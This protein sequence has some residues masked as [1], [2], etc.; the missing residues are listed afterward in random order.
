MHFRLPRLALRSQL[1]IQQLNMIL[2]LIET[3]TVRGAA[4]ELA[5]SQSAVT[6]SL[7]ELESLLGVPLFD[8]DARGLKPTIYCAPLEQFARDTLLGLDAAVGSI[9]N[10][11]RGHEGRVCIGAN[12]GYAENTLVDTLPAIR[13]AFP[14]LVVY[15]H[16]GSN[17]ELVRQL[18]SGEL[19]FALLSPPLH[20]DRSH[21]TFLPLTNEPLVSVVRPS[22]P[23]ANSDLLVTSDLLDAAWVLPPHQDPLRELIGFSLMASGSDEPSELI[24]AN[25]ISMALDLAARLDLVTVAP[26]SLARPMLAQ[27]RLVVVK[28]SYALTPMRVGVLRY[29]RR[30]LRAGAHGVLATLLRTL[31][32]ARRGNR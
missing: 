28:T 10:L 6:K 27:G 29:R 32:A 4:D 22:H 12:P 3:G 1:R 20:L 9:R 13:G 25:S 8:R 24:E 11:L 21:Y 23:F 17:V 31:R 30:E 15:L 19:D 7:K 18:D 26:E 2:R 16:S 14:R 5:L